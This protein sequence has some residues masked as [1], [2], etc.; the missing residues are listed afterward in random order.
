MQIYLDTAATTPLDTKVITLMKKSLEKDYGNP[1]SL[2]KKGREAKELLEKSRKIIAKTINANSEEIYFMSSGT[3]A[4]NLAIQGIL[5][6]GK[7][8]EIIISAIEHASIKNLC[9]ELE[10]EDFTIHKIPVDKQGFVQIKELKKRFNEK[11]ALVSIMYA[12]NET[13]ILQNVAEIGNLCAQK[14]IPFHTDAVQAYKKIPI[15]IKKIKVTSL[16]LS[17]HKIYGPKGIAA[18]YLRKNIDCKPIIFG[19][20]QERSLRSGTENLPAI[21]G[22]AKAAQLSYPVKQI[23]QKKEYLIKNL[24]EIPNLKINTPQES[25]CNIINFSVEG[26]DGE[27]LV[28]YLSEQGI[29]VSTGSACS[30]GSVEPSYVLKALGLSDK[31]ARSSIRISLAK[32]T[33]KQDLDKTIKHLKYLISILRK[34]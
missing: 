20:G 14:N 8:K 19:G 15:D 34:L 31:Q 25:V 27:T 13:G 2:H 3:E 29:Y 30:S 33:T 9:E 24:K 17:A 12:N 5:K 32:D 28:E 1:S 11:T 22:F 21:L 23:Q 4:N 7:K 10:K 26:V 6:A 16:T 18:L